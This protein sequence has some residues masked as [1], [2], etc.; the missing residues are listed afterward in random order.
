MEYQVEESFF[1]IFL[2]VQRGSYCFI[3]PMFRRAEALQ[4]SGL[5][6]DNRSALE[7][8]SSSSP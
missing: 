6:F 2:T 8:P 3:S 7:S 1:G 4:R 5:K